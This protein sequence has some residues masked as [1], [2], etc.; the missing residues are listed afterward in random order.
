MVLVSCDVVLIVSRAP[1]SMRPGPEVRVGGM[2]LRLA[3]QTVD[4]VSHVTD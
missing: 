3:G 4:D 1:G 2:V